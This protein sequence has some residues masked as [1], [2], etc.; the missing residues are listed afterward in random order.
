[1]QRFWEQVDKRG[2]D[3]CWEWQGGID[4]P[5]CDTCK[6]YGF[7]AGF[8]GLKVG[9]HRFAYELVIGKIPPKRV[10]RH[11]CDNPPCC[12]PAHLLVGTQADNMA[13]RMTA[14]KYQR[15]STHY[16]AKLTED[17]VREIRRRWAAGETQADLAREFGIKQGTISNVVRGYSWKHVV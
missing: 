12:N 16:A 4:P 1:M 13:D 9:A 7:F 11:S 3:E 6:G 15:G 17:S 10:V 14:G 5:N 8:A 2:P